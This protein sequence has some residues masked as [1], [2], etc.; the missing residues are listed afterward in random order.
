MPRP[1]AR[2]R[3][4]RESKST[5]LVLCEGRNTERHYFNAVKA[6][7]RAGHIEI[8]SDK[9]QGLTALQMQMELARRQ[10]LGLLPDEAFCVFDLDTHGLG[11]APVIQQLEAFRGC[12]T[13]VVATRPCFEYWLLEHFEHTLAPFADCDQIVARLRTHLPDYDK[14]DSD[15]IRRFVEDQELLQRGLAN[16]VN[17]TKTF[18]G[19]PCTKV[20]SLLAHL[21]GLAAFPG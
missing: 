13:R 2:R 20:G 16:Y 17:C 14:S 4:V 11:Q 5:I 3:F 10:R 8:V 12:K 6:K 15:M 19:N 21:L 1:E 7:L 9:N 18:D